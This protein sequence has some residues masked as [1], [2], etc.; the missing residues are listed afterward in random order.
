MSLKTHSQLCSENFCLNRKEQKIYNGNSAHK[1]QLSLLCPFKF[2]LLIKTQTKLNI[3]LCKST[4]V[5]LF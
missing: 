4:L 2:I 1:T 3:V 5:T